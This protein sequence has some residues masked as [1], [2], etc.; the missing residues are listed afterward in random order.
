M[1]INL[2]MWVADPGAASQLFLLDTEV[3][4]PLITGDHVVPEPGI[5]ETFGIANLDRDVVDILLGPNSQGVL[6]VHNFF[7]NQDGTGSFQADFD[8]GVP[9]R[10][11]TIIATDDVDNQSNESPIFLVQSRELAKLGE[12]FSIVPQATISTS[13]CQNLLD[14]MPRTNFILKR[15]YT[16]P[17]SFNPTIFELRAVTPGV[18]VEIMVVRRDLSGKSDETQRYV[19][20]P[21]QPI[22][23][24]LIRLGRGNNIITIVDQEGRADTIVVSATTYAA[25][26]C[27]YAREIYDY[28]QVKIEDQRTAIYSP[29]ST[30]LAEPLLIFSNLL[31]DVKSQQTLATKLAVR[32]LVGSP[33]KQSG[34]RD[35]LAALTLSTPIFMPENSED[36]WFEPAVRPLFNSQEAF[37]GVEAHVWPANQC[38]KRWLAFVQYI[39]NVKVFKLVSISEHEV[40]FYDENGDL[41]RHQFD[42]GTDQCS[43]TTL[44]LQSICFENID[45]RLS[46]FSESDL[47]ICAA[48]YPFDMRPVP[49]FP[50]HLVDQEDVVDPGFDGYVGFSVTGRWDS[51]TPLDSQGAMPALGSSAP[52]CVYENG[53]LTVPLLMGGLQ[54]Q[55]D[56]QVSIVDAEYDVE[57][58]RGADLDIWISGVFNQE[59]SLDINI[60]ATA[61]NSLVQAGM[62]LMVNPGISS[63]CNVAVAGTVPR[64]VG[65]DLAISS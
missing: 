1:S 28:S 7:N 56:N 54:Y 41:Q 32:A 29:V 10:S 30:R 49:R 35:L 9:T 61:G 45:V 44:A 42:F 27:S 40:V 11:M 64:A 12:V 52:R 55:I 21:D 50:V 3:S 48:T 26:L 47:W 8:P 36:Q 22:V 34:V 20:A 15:R 6:A 46:I 5:S 62:D 53:Y 18:P 17:Y 57:P 23:Q 39:N 19:V 60:E 43:L 38:I 33:G 31:P 65:L 63:N 16:V 4:T 58:G 13:T 59:A 14:A 24:V 2:D 37:G 25:L 51:R